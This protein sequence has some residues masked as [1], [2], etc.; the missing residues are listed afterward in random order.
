MDDGNASISFG[1]EFTDRA[2]ILLLL[3]SYYYTLFKLMF[4]CPS[5]ETP[6]N[7]IFLALSIASYSL[8]FFKANLA[9]SSGLIYSSKV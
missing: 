1:Y 4:S 7:F 8:Y 5:G 2:L 3:I 6:S 9:S